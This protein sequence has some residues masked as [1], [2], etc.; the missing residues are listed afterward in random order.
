M[1]AWTFLY[2]AVCALSV[3]ASLY[4]L[5]RRNLELVML[6]AGFAM[7]VILLSQVLPWGV[8]WEVTR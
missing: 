1:I 3:F 7:I 4:G 2:G 8:W 5:A 6:G